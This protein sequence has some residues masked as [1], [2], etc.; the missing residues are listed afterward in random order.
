MEMHIPYRR[1]SAEMSLLLRLM[2]G[3]AK[4]P[5][6]IDRERL[7]AMI[8]KNRLEPMA[9]ERLDGAACLD[10]AA[11]EAAL[12]TMRQI[13]LLGHLAR[14]FAQQGIR[15]LS[16]KGP[17][18]AMEIYGTPGMRSNHDLDL[19]VD[20]TQLDQAVKLL[21]QDGWTWYEGDVLT[22]PKRRAESLRSQNHYLF[23]KG[24]IYLELHWR[25]R[26]WDCDAFE[27][28]W[29][30]RRQVMLGGAEI[31]VPGVVHQLHHLVYHG[32][33]HGFHRMKWLA[34]LAVLLPRHTGDMDALWHSLAQSGQDM[35]LVLT[36]VLLL[37]LRE[38][39]I[40]DVSFGGVTLK[41]TDS[42]VLAS[43]TGKAETVLQQ[44]RKLLDTLIP[45]LESPI[46]IEQ[47]MPYLKY[48]TMLS[49]AMHCRGFLEW[50]VR[51]FRPC[52]IVW[53]WI[54]LPDS[55]YGLYWI[56]RPLERVRRLLR[57]KSAAKRY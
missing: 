18:L 42:G 12:T 8:R 26:P 29:E 47:T 24:D 55:L 31:A 54:D 45:L 23:I 56:L 40:P 49:K 5:A 2:Q 32:V 6:E 16:V 33:S 25:L 19:L 20:S 39:V 13:S 9:A 14:L 48:R 22:T 46:E 7:Q 41:R 52:V 11:D 51:E 3:E 44:V 27:Q 38:L 1:T 34:D 15:V 53:R 35:K 36:W 21:A 30:A 28:L 50:T 17:A 10:L 37:S 57:E 43:G 4:L